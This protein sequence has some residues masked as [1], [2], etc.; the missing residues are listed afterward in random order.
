MKHASKMLRTSSK[1]SLFKN[2]S[3]K[4]ELEKLNLNISLA[5]GLL[6]TLSTNDPSVWTRKCRTKRAQEHSRILLQE[7]MDE[8]WNAEES[9]TNLSQKLLRKS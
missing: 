6:A 1:K 9:L 4:L 3:I 5:K 8:I 7:V 2:G